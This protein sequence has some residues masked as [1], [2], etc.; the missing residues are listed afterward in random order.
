M[1]NIVLDN[2]FVRCDLAD[3]RFKNWTFWLPDV[4]IRELAST[5]KI[6][7][8]DIFKDVID[9]VEIIEHIWPMISKERNS[10][11]SHSLIIDNQLTKSF[12]EFIQ[13]DM[14][15][16]KQSIGSIENFEVAFKACGCLYQ[17]FKTCGFP[18]DKF[19]LLDQLSSSFLCENSEVIPLIAK[20]ILFS[21]LDSELWEKFDNNWIMYQYTRAFFLAVIWRHS[22]GALMKNPKKLNN[23]MRDLEYL[24]YLKHADGFA[25]K[26]KNLLIYARTLFPKIKL[27]SNNENFNTA[28]KA[29]LNFESN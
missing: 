22:Q 24:P 20:G 13:K 11:E 4:L 17:T 9:R 15:L 1:L 29:F 12:K 19:E 3:N 8:K 5:D 23:E 26:D 25:S 6:D 7:C 16:D 28:E 14:D 2:S 27:F 21:G 10:K 18:K